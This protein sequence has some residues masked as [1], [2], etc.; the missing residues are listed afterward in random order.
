MLRVLLSFFTLIVCTL[1]SLPA[2]DFAAID[3]HAT[4]FEASSDLP[5]T[6]QEL[7]APYETELEKARAIFTYVATSMRYDCHEYRRKPHERI[8]RTRPQI[9]ARA[10]K[11]NMGV[12]AGYA[13]L[14]DAMCEAVG[15]NSEVIS[16]TSRLG[17]QR[18]NLKRLPEDHAWNA[19]EIDGK[20]YL[21]DAT[22]ASGYVNPEATKFT[23][24]FDG[25]LFMQDPEIFF[26]KHF[27]KDPSWQL[28]PEERSA[29]AFVNQPVVYRI[30]QTWMLTDFTPRVGSLAKEETTYEF[31]IHLTGPEKMFLTMGDRRFEMTIGEDGYYSYSLPRSAIRGRT[32]ALRALENRRIKSVVEYRVGN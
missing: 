5:T 24:S 4:N 15:L 27:P 13:I 11:R 23:A 20:W 17:W 21:L 1:I 32:V 9:L 18:F 30:P 3:E 28:L 19:V 10:F 12:C 2:Q 14:F 29:E 7:V 16:G 31:R 26:L 8:A 6:A 25:R 22:W